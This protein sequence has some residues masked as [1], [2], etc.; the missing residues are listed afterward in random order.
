MK[1]QWSFDEYFFEEDDAILLADAAD[2]LEHK[3][4][5][6]KPFGNEFGERNINCACPC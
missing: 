2:Y 3:S 1:I 5:L 6:K 4:R